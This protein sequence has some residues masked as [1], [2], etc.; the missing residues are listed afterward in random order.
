MTTAAVRAS[1]RR[2]CTARTCL[3]R[4]RRRRRRRLSFPIATAS[5]I[6]CRAS[7][8]VPF[9]RARPA[10]ETP[11]KKMLKYTDAADIDPKARTV[12]DFHPIE[13]ARQ[14]A[15]A[16]HECFVAVRPQELMSRAWMKDSADVHAQKCP[17]VK[18][19]IEQF[20]R[21]NRW[22]ASEIVLVIDDAKQRLS[23]LKRMIELAHCCREVQNLHAMYAIYVGLN[24]WAVQRLKAL[25]AALPAKWQKRY[26]EL[27]ELANPKSNSAA[28][29]A[30]L[31][32]LDPPI[33]PPI[34]L[35]LRDMT[36]LGELD[37]FV[38]VSAAV[39]A[40]TPALPPPLPSA[41]DGSAAAR[42][43]RCRLR[44]TTS[45]RFTSTRAILS[46]RASST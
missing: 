8:R 24:M 21:I 40:T 32:T 13:L 46:R 38:E 18:R 39:A 42:R 4:D 5:R 2:I 43:C 37:E 20:N 16:A 7:R 27:D 36:A 25:W 12:L 34:D 6:V 22:V 28:M 3:C 44:A 17:N 9:H 11:S 26:D 14:L 41:D 35:T 1:G 15:L 31:R 23:V 33:V 29:R 45:S 19:M 10:H 30:L